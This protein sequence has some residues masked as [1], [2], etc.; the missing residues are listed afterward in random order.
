M[1]F[2]RGISLALALALVAG[3]G[4]PL[5]I[6]AAAADTGSSDALAAL[7]IDSSK[8]PDGFNAND[9]TTNPYGR[10]TIKVTPVYE[11]YTVGLTEDVLPSDKITMGSK[12]DAASCE[13]NTSQSNDKNNTLQSTLYGH[14]DNSSI[15]AESFLK[16]KK[17]QQ[18]ISV[19]KTTS[20]GNYVQFP[21]GSKNGDSY[22]TKGYLTGMTNATTDLNDG[23]DYAMADVAA[24]HFT[25]SSDAKSEQVAMVYAGDLSASG[26]LYLRFGDATT[27]KYGN[28]ITLLDTSK[29]IGNPTLKDAAETSGSEKTEEKLVENFAE[30]PYQ[31]KNYLQVATGDWDNDGMD[32]VAVYVPEVGSSRIE[33][34]D[35][36]DKNVSYNNPSNWRQ[37]WTYYFREGSVV[38]NMISIVSG[39]VNQDGVDD[40]ACT[41]GYY[42]GPQQ[43][44][45]SRAVVMFGST[46][47]HMLQSAQ[48]FPL[49]YQG[50][51]LVRA[52]FAFG[53]M[54][55]G[56]KTLI[57]AAQADSDL[58]SGK[59]NTRYVG[60]YAWNGVTFKDSASKNFDLFSKDKDG[61]YIYSAMEGHTEKGTDVF[62]SLPLCPANT[63]IISRPTAGEVDKST[64]NDNDKDSDNGKTSDLLY[65]DSLVI[66]CDENGLDIKQALDNTAAMP[67]E[68]YVEYDASAGAVTTAVDKDNNTAGSGTLFTLTQ[69]MSKDTEKS[70]EAYTGSGSIQVPVYSTGYYYKNWLHKLFKKKSSYTYISGY[71]TETITTSI[72]EKYNQRTP[73]TTALSTVNLFDG[74]QPV[75]TDVNSSYSLCLANTDDDTSYMTY[76]G[77]HYYTYTDPQV[78]AVLASPP[79]F[80]DLLDRDDLSGNYAESTTSYSSMKGTENGS[81]SSSTISVGAY[82]S[83]EQEFSVFGVKIGSVEAE[84]AFTA[85]FTY[86]TEHTSSL[87]Q[88]ITYE[89]TSGE[90]RVAFYSIPM[91][92]YEYTSYIPDDQGHYTAV[93]STVS[94]PH[95]ASIGLIDL[96]EYENIAEDYSVLPSISGSVLTHTL[97]DPSSYPSKEYTGSK[98]YNG[99]PAKV[100]YSAAGGGSGITQEISFSTSDSKAYT[101]T[102][103]IETKAG[104]G[105]GG[106]TAGVV[107]G[108]ESSAGTVSVNTA[109]G[110]FSGALQNMPIEAKEFGYGMNWRI[111]CYNYRSGSQSF[112]VVT[113]AVSDPRSPSPLPEDFEQDVAKTTE[114]SV[115]L[116]WTYDKI[117][118]GFQ[119]Y[120]YYDFPS[121]SG[122]KELAF[123]PFTSGEPNNDGTYTF[124]YTD[125]NLSPYT[126]YEYQIQTCNNNKAENLRK[127]IY[128]EA[129]TC[130]TKT[131]NGYPDISVKID[132]IKGKTVLPIY[133]DARATATV[134]YAEPTGGKYNSVNYQWQK[135]DNGSWTDIAGSTSDTLSIEN[136]GSADKG[137]YRCRLNVLYFD[138]T[139]QKEFSISAFSPEITT[140]YSKRTPKCELNVTP[141]KAQIGGTTQYNRIL[142]I[143][144]KMSAASDTSRS[145]PTGTLSFLIRGTD[146]SATVAAEIAENGHVTK[147]VTVP[148]DGA[149]TVTPYY[150]G[151]YVFKDMSSAEG[152]MVL[153]GNNVTGYQLTLT[154]GKDNNS[155]TRFTY[156]DT[157]TPSLSRMTKD[158]KGLEKISATFKYAVSG[159]KAE[160]QDLPTKL[161]IGTYTLYAYISG[162]SEPVAETEFTVLPRAVTLRVVTPS[163]GVAQTEVNPNDKNQL[164]LTAD[165]KNMSDTEI[166]ALHFGFTAVNSAGTET[167]LKA[168]IAP[169][170]YTV[171]PCKTESTNETLY[172]NYDFTFI[173]G[174]YTVNGTTYALTLQA[175]DFG[176]GAN[177]HSVASVSID[178]AGLNHKKIA[179]GV[180]ANF[181]ANT[182]VILSTVPDPGYAV[183]HWTYAGETLKDANGKTITDNSVTITT[184]AQSAIAQVYFKTTDTVLNAFVQGKKGGTIKCIDEDGYETLKNFP[185]YI[186]SGAKYSFTATPNEGWHF[187]QW[188]LSERGAN[189]YPSGT[190]H[191]D[192]SN[193]LSVEVGVRD[194]DLV[195]VFERDSYTLTLDGE[196]TA[197]YVGTD[198]KDDTKQITI[199]IKNGE[200]LTGDTQITVAP[201]AGYVAAEG[202]TYKLNDT[203]VDKAK[204]NTDGSYTFPLTENTKVSLKTDRAS[205]VIT[206]PEME[207]GKIVA[208]VDGETV[209]DLS[210]I[211]GGSKVELQ[212]RAERGWHFKNWVVNGEAQNE[213]KAKTNGTYTISEL[214]GDLS[215]YAE[216]AE[217]DSYT[218][219]AAAAN[220]NGTIAYTLYDIYGDEFE[221][222]TMPTE[223]VTIYKD[224]EITF[225]ATPKAGYQVEQWKVDSKLTTTNSETN[226]EGRIRAEKNIDITVYLKVST[227]Y[228]LTFGTATADGS[229]AAK[230]G[231]D[232]ITTGE[233]QPNSSKITF[234]AVPNA[235]KMVEKWTV[236]KG[237]ISTA[238]NEAAVQANGVDLVD[239]VYVHTLSGNQTIRVHFT[240][241]VQYDA[242]ITGTNGTGSF[243]Y[244]TP[245]QPN[246]NG[247]INKTATQVR[248]NG[249]VKLTLKPSTNCVG[250]AEEIKTELQKAAPNAVVDVTEKD[251]GTFEAIIRNVTA[252]LTVNTDTLFHQTYAITAN[253]AENGSVSASAVRVKAGDKVT[254]TVTPASGYQLKTL[255]LAP[256]TALDKTVSASTLTYTFTM[257]DKDVA[258]TATFA[259]KPSSGGGI[260]GGGGAGGGGAVAPAPSD[261][262]SSSITAP[263][264]TKVPATV[265]VKDGTATVSADSSKLT[266]VS[267]KDSLTLDLSS[268]STIRTV[269][270]TGDVVTALAGAK[271]GVSLTLPNG[272]VTL[273]RETLTALGSAAQADGTA[274][275]S[276]ASADK[277]SLT[278]AQRKYLPK[279]GMILNIS[280]QVQPKNGTVTRVH[281]LNGTASISVAYSLKSGETAS[282]L[283]A[284]YLAEDGSFE[285]LP[286]TYDAATGKAT[287]KTGHFSTF[288]ITHEYSSDF[289]DV[290]LRKWF[291]NE[292]NT[293]L[294]N[295]WF[296]GL[297]ATKFGPDDGMT[298]AMLV[299][300][301]YR[302][303]GS[304]AA[305]TAQF[306]DVADGKWYAEA[307]AWASENGI[308]NGFTDGRFQPDTLITR[309][310]LAAIL[311]RYDTY[312]G[313]TPQGSAAL[314]GYADAASVESWAAEAMSWANG[315]GLVTGVT[316]T[317]LVPNGT[318]TRAQV[319]VI[320]SRYTGK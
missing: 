242:K 228:V 134:S 35:L 26:G 264:G 160:P 320:L 200:S 18:T 162:V 78:L 289:S 231:N 263:D 317:T 277:S 79:Y 47:A 38:S 97:G 100:D 248:K 11:L 6:R 48:E 143:N 272:T 166:D 22:D 185:A 318:A 93:T 295:G 133:P 29:Q 71:K 149:Y 114:D 124:S 85:G 287:F 68:D 239:P 117:V 174:I 28:P 293:A 261:N 96:S 165:T 59:Q 302:M 296:K 62:R 118:S 120:R 17:T 213:A 274:S 266:T 53:D 301:L 191:D 303:S 83:F 1:K 225:N 69:T 237:S 76:S 226:P 7:G 175:V 229:L 203:A 276:I 151:S 30:N 178:T 245:I 40:L 54:T 236:T 271:N 234:T 311:Y 243:T 258:V 316:P 304:K 52:S 119:L 95:E 91:E 252:A 137:T 64:S 288:V 94:I 253:K 168:G 172:S 152:K 247:T 92:I 290:N 14:D 222:K 292:V 157:V 80:S 50:S 108:S 153:V 86:E 305:S 204:L 146:Y 312:R 15:T 84:A 89:T 268:D 65:F 32:E 279:N 284:Y 123:V 180:T 173:P 233:K 244:T 195:A 81:T 286:V 260:G 259:A 3:M 227:K 217:S 250:T 224:E 37:A 215:I 265:E 267:G 300:V 34:Y 214:A 13:K 45:G 144:A 142:H 315:N 254:L 179:N 42:Y 77:K 24:G 66:S 202:E 70:A 181:Q 205:F 115:T 102:A 155:V 41:W 238:E 255:T 67:N 216:F 218:A 12:A 308:V 158:S 309:Q 240:D 56:G 221:T 60:L 74:S 9:T 112:P 278:D 280:A 256:E 159:S 167:E 232:T 121:G 299:Q 199:P 43:N 4:G 281:E 197:S 131:Q 220:N 113:Y 106:V 82:V 182:D 307:I 19:G 212:A 275:I 98:A 141:E 8:A 88:S 188:I 283:V 125:N 23:T 269:S 116:T 105:A 177:K 55:G 164:S 210:E 319:A 27:G 176:E 51:N 246:D 75:K 156:G 87:E 219:K 63:A 135:L 206:T 139:A 20:T 186:S 129:L 39:D 291:Y 73:G 192:G 132:G 294:E 270:L 198:P 16:T 171:S 154:N 126:E 61:N 44:A 169:S 99:T 145:I 314:D 235:N 138:N 107:A 196:I 183:D 46:S 10:S 163:S 207:H 110:S 127:S 57:L 130:R 104:A 2:K 72:T 33:I 184:R 273:D 262:G 147:D 122:R 170:N 5:D 25:D 241:L 211:P 230:I 136:A 306:T 223:G 257:P 189:T 150:P 128:S 31:L 285:K 103:S 209:N 36:Q 208:T 49:T 249:T 313:H 298:R 148:A 109:G 161:N 58:K 201:K 21:V 101:N 187:K 193:T 297:T 251:D 90:D 140:Q 111:F 190:K 310:Q 282:H 194:I